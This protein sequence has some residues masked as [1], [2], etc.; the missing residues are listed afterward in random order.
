MTLAPGTRLGGFRV[1]PVAARGGWSVVHWGTELSSGRAVA[2]KTIAPELAEDPGFRARFER[3]CEIAGAV[4]HESL[5]PVRGAGDGWLALDWI[6]GRRL[7][8]RVPLS[9]ARAARVVAQVAGALDALHGAGFVHRDVK[10]GNVLVGGDGHAY[11]TDLGT[12]KPIDSDPGLTA[13]GRWLGH[14]D[15]AAPEQIRGEPV[16]ARADV[17]ALGATLFHAVTGRVPYPDRDDEARMRAHLH[18]PPPRHDSELD[19]VVRRAMAKDPAERFPSA[20]ELGAAA[21]DAAG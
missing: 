15:Y 4:E 12:A 18:E 3:E 11:L 14:V 13:E 2:L 6:D 10:P 19:P 7:R 9:P 8:E 5:V 17:Y 20:G 21:L 1:G 16:D